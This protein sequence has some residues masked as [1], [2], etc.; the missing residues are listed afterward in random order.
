MNNIWR[1]L[2]HRKFGSRSAAAKM[3]NVLLS[4]CVKQNAAHDN[5]FLFLKC[6]SWMDKIDEWFECCSI[7]PK[8]VRSRDSS[9]AM[10]PSISHRIGTVQGLP[11]PWY[12]SAMQQWWI[13]YYWFESCM[14][15]FRHQVNEVRPRVISRYNAGP[16]VIL[17]PFPVAGTRGIER[18]VKIPC[19][20]IHWSANTK[21]WKVPIIVMN[22]WDVHNYLWATVWGVLMGHYYTGFSFSSL[23]S[24]PKTRQTPIISSSQLFYYEANEANLE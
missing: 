10:D 9:T 19:M 17:S 24:Q 21:K 2:A 5:F 8:P 12:Y 3:A 23:V 14:M 20:D 6:Y 11:F 1:S 7:L 22:V 15:G 4:P 18:V 16:A 13:I